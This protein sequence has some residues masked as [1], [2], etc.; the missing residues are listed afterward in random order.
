ME[1]SA[2]RRRFQESLLQ[3]DLKSPSRMP[4]AMKL[5]P[6]ARFFRKD[7]VWLRHSLRVL[8]PVDGIMMERSTLILQT[9]DELEVH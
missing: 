6:W 4:V 3:S 9:L 8:L 1:S 5:Q 7:A 2:F